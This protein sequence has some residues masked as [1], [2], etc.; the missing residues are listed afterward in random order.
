MQRQPT[1]RLDK[2]RKGHNLS[3]E[4]TK[5]KIRGE[6]TFTDL[7]DLPS[8]GVDTRKAG[9]KLKVRRDENASKDAGI[10]SWE[11]RKVRAFIKRYECSK[12]LCVYAKTDEGN[13]RNRAVLQQKLE[14][15]VEQFCCGDLLFDDIHPLSKVLLHQKQLAQEVVLS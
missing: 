12:G 14:T 2:D 3:T 4:D 5:A 9:A 11:G 15:V 10:R 6:A 8:N 1:P 7:E 13:W